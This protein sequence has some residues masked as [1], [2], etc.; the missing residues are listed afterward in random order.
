MEPSPSSS[1]I[2]VRSGTAAP[3]QVRRPDGTLVRRLTF[4]PGCSVEGLGF[5]DDH[6][7]LLQVREHESNRNRLVLIDLRTGADHVVSDWP[8]TDTAG[9]LTAGRATLAA[10]LR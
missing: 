3:I 4:A 1:P 2:L 7:Y 5:A 6:R 8:S 10:M 9:D